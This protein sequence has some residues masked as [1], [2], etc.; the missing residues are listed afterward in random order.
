M[1][2]WIQFLFVAFETNMKFFSETK[3]ADLMMLLSDS[4]FKIMN[5]YYVLFR[6]VVLVLWKRVERIYMKVWKLSWVESKKQL[7]SCPYSISNFIAV[8]DS[9]SFSFGSGEGSVLNPSTKSENIKALNIGVDLFKVSRWRFSL[10]CFKKSTNGSVFLD[11]KSTMIQFRA[12]DHVDFFLGNL[13]SWKTKVILHFKN[14]KIINFTRQCNS[15]FNQWRL[16]EPRVPCSSWKRLAWYQ[17]TL[18]IW[19]IQ[20]ILLLDQL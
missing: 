9:F 3:V 20:E 8:I 4:S 13:L 12:F 17:I 14:R 7:F 1:F 6:L 10:L 19:K 15:K 16:L 2:R 11:K 18:K 5:Y